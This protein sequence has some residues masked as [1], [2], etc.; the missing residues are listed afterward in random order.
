MK[1][2]AMT[3]TS[4]NSI[5]GSTAN[6][7]VPA[8]A[9]VLAVSIVSSATPTATEYVDGITQAVQALEEL[10]AKMENAEEQ[11]E[12]SSEEMAKRADRILKKMDHEG[13]RDEQRPDKTWL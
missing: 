11:Q 3:A 9:G 12:L 1:I 2:G 13:G 7:T 5:A 6:L 8:D 10:P 4:T